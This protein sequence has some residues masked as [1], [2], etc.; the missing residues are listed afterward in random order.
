MPRIY[1][2]TDGYLTSF[3]GKNSAKPIGTMKSVTL[4]DLG[5]PDTVST[6]AEVY[7]RY[8]FTGNYRYIQVD[9]FNVAGMITYHQ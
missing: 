9:N 3:Y 7:Q 1:T 6:E 4:Q 5:W 8:G 2:A